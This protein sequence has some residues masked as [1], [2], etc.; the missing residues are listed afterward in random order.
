MTTPLILHSLAWYGRDLPADT[1]HELAAIG[2]GSLLLI[3][4]PP[5]DYAFEQHALPEFIVCIDGRIGI[6]TSDGDLQN[7]SVGQMIEIT[8]GVRHR[9]ASDSDA[10]ILTLAQRA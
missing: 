6:E 10:V 3:H 1:D 5:G 4:V 8:A 9:F 2:R 7:A